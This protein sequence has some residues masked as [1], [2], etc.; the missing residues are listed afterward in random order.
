MLPIN[1]RPPGRNN[2]YY[3]KEINHADISDTDIN[4]DLHNSIDD[5]EVAALI[6][7]K[8]ACNEDNDEDPDTTPW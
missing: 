8:N 4:Q 2:H 6:S 1:A 5:T 7:L 3:P